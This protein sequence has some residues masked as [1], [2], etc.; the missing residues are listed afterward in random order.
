LTGSQFFERRVSREYTSRKNNS[1]WT[2]KE[3][4]RLKQGVYKFGA[5]GAIDHGSMQVEEDF[6]QN[7]N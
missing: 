1:R 2:A 4:E 3:V 5:I 6:F 7:V